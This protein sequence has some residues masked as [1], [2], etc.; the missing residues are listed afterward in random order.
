VSNSEHGRSGDGDASPRDSQLRESEDLLGLA[1]EAGRLGI[2]EWQ[3]PA[4]T[5][6]LSPKFLSL[7]GL[8]GFDGRY[9]SWRAC[10]FR[11]DQIRINQLI[12]SAFEAGARELKAEFAS[13]ARAM[14]CSD[15]SKPAT[16]FSTMTSSV[17][18]ALSAS[19]ST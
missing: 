8:A 3:V 14:A 6:R 7:Y 10:I 9:E 11:E 19:T 15:G 18:C 5:V 2:F 17:R 4:G 16:L 13:P 12:E 1:E